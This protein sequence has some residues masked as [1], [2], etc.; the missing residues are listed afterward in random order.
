MRHNPLDIQDVGLGAMKFFRS[1][2]GA[3]KGNEDHGR[4]RVSKRRRSHSN[5]IRSSRSDDRRRRRRV[6]VCCGH[7]GHIEH[8]EHVGHHPDERYVKCLIFFG[9]RRMV[10]W[11]INCAAGPCAGYLFGPLSRQHWG[12]T[13]AGMFQVMHTC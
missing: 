8:V 3:Y 10:P 5:T 9:H 2:L 1:W 12:Y 4:V 13:A 6:S 11:N 7:V